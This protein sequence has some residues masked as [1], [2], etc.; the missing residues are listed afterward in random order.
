MR[1][2]VISFI[3]FYVSNVS[4]GQQFLRA[5]NE[6]KL[7]KKLLDL[8]LMAPKAKPEPKTKAPTLQPTAGPP[9]LAPTPKAT[10]APSN[11]K[12]TPATNAPVTSGPT[13]P[14]GAVLLSP[15]KDVTV[16]M[17]WGSGNNIISTTVTGP[18]LSI[19]DALS[20]SGADTITWA[21]ATGSCNA[22]TWAG[23]D[24]DAIAQANIPR[25]LSSGKKYIIST[26]GAVGSFKCSSD[27]NFEAFINRY[28][29]ANMIALDFDIEGG[30]LTQ[31]DINNL[32]QRVK[33]MQLAGKFPSLKYSFTLATLGGTANP[34][35]GTDG[36]KVMSAIQS[37]GISNYYINLM[38]MDYFSKS[39]WSCVLGSDGR[40]DMGKSAVQAATSL[41]N[42]Y[43]LPYNQIG[44][45]PMIGTNDDTSE[46]FNVFDDVDEVSSFALR[47]GLYAVHFWAFDRDKDCPLGP[48]QN[49]CNSYGQAGTLGFTKKFANYLNGQSDPVTFPTQAPQAS[50]APTFAA[51]LAPGWNLCYPSAYCAP[52]S[53][54]VT[55]SGVYAS[56]SACN[57]QCQSINNVYASFVPS[58]GQ[59]LCTNTCSSQVANGGVDSYCNGG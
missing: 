44:I 19:T 31:T 56:P 34:I 1:V 52:M 13:F 10:A 7:E 51:T 30:K 53:L 38:T 26:G 15:Y 5:I 40:C 14:P 27:S 20:L 54:L 33:N 25:F 48:P 12:P 29:S 55:Q 50:A 17:D 18:R 23:I 57:L 2:V 37:V 39:S 49:E 3:L 45:T 9:T 43:N 46:V 28:Y 41:H 35:L 58:S 8:N 42:Q 4:F 47:V 21:F 16:G 36:Q 24:K 32:V 6:F 59:C 22:E 11:K